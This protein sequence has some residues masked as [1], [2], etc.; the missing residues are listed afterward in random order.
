MKRFSKILAVLLSA[1][2]LLA[3]LPAVSLAAGGEVYAVYNAADSTLTFCV[4]AL[5]SDGVH[6]DAGGEPVTGDAYYT[7]FLNSFYSSDVNPAPWRH[8]SFSSVVFLDEIKPTTTRGWFEDTSLTEFISTEKFNTSNVTSMSNMFFGCSS[9]L[10]LDVSCFDT[11]NVKDMSYMFASCSGIKELDLSNFD[12]SQVENMSMMFDYCSSLKRIVGL[13]KFDTSSVKSTYG[14]FEACESLTEI[15]LSSF[16]TSSLTSMGGMFQGCESIQTLNVSTFTTD[17]VTSMWQSF[18]Y[19][20]SLQSLDLSNFDMSAVTYLDGIFTGLESLSSLTL[21]SKFPFINTGLPDAPY[22]SPYTGFWIKEGTS[23]PKYRVSEL[24]NLAGTEDIGGT[25]VWE[26]SGTVPVERIENTLSQSE[27]NIGETCQVTSTVY[28]SNATNK[29][30]YYTISEGSDVAKVDYYTGVVTGLTAGSY[31][32]CCFTSDSGNYYVSG[33]VVDPSEP[34][35]V[36]G[37]A[38]A[39]FNKADGTL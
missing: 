13:N 16:I 28:P 2:L 18:A 4:G 9:L 26:T 14:M 37:E 24:E 23:W 32:V 27:I 5:E 8:A 1:C 15:D 29:T 10:A 34:P 17:Q 25:W 31:T 30:V 35:V 39:V 36:T 19:C 22:N 12:T 33:T 7:G 6:R 21:P 3:L 20:E 11:G 38:Y